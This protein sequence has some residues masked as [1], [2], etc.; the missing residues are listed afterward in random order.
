MLQISSRI[1]FALVGLLEVWS[2]M[3]WQ[4]LERAE[5]PKFDLMACWFPAAIRSC[6]VSLGRLQDIELECDH[7]IIK[8]SCVFIRCKLV[9]I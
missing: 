6:F 7:T 3:V 5:S 4:E 9:N 1:N 8:A 2:L